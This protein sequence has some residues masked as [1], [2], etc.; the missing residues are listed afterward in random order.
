MLRL[1]IAG[2][3]YVANQV[4]FFSV[5]PDVLNLCS[6]CPIFIALLVSLDNLNV[7]K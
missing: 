6:V 2:T 1:L 3:E 5:E 4:S 7:S